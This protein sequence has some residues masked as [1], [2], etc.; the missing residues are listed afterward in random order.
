MRWMKREGEPVEQILAAIDE[1]ADIAMLVL[2]ANPGAEG[3]GPL[4]TLL[5]KTVG[6]FPVPVVVVP[7][8]LADADIDALS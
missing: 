8:D 4:I 6:S 3:P 5:A 1:D 7:G 2:A